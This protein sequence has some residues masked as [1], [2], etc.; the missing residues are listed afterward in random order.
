MTNE[1]RKARTSF[2]FERKNND[3]A[4]KSFMDQLNEMIKDFERQTGKTV[5]GINIDR[6]KFKG[7]N[8]ERTLFRG[9]YVAVE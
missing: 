6:D 1:D 5:Q 9:V 4:R 8:Y 7:V 3:A 2:D